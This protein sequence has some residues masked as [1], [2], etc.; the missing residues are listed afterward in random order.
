M[1][2][3]LLVSCLFV[4][5]SFCHCFMES[6][7][8]CNVCIP[9]RVFRT[10]WNPDLGVS[11]GIKFHFSENADIKYLAIKYNNFTISWKKAAVF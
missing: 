8:M 10:E 7:S 11:D 9:I 6:F 3:Y 2:A 5:L 1:S 4:S